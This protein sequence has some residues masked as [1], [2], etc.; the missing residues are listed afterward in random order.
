MLPARRSQQVPDRR[1]QK[2]QTMPERRHAERLIMPDR[3]RHR[4]RCLET[5]KSR[6]QSFFLRHEEG[7]AVVQNLRGS[8]F[9]LLDKKDVENL[10]GQDFANLFDL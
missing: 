8:N 5:Q 3:R 6:G 1:R 9:A 4:E 10:R 7:R 2:Y